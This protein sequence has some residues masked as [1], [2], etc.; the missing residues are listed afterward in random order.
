[1]KTHV[2]SKP[3]HTSTP[4]LQ[5]IKL[6]RLTER[7]RINHD[8]QRNDAR[9]SKEIKSKFSAML[10]AR[11]EEL[12]KGLLEKYGSTRTK[13]DIF[14]GLLK[15]KLSEKFRRMQ[16]K[17][18]QRALAVAS[19]MY[20]IISRKPNP[21]A[22]LHT[23]VKR[24]NVS[25]PRGSDPCRTIVECLFDYGS[26]PEERTDKRQY[27]CT[28]A[29]ALRYIIRKGI[30]PQKV[31]TP[32]QGESITNWAKREAQFCRQKTAS[33]TP[34]E[35]PKPKRSMKSESA[36]GELPVRRLSERRYRMLQK[37]AKT[38]VFLVDPEHNGRTLVVTV[39]KLASL[40]VDE[41]KRRP[42]KVRAEIQKTL[43]KAIQ[44]AAEK[45]PTMPL[46]P[47]PAINTRRSISFRTSPFNSIEA[48]WPSAPRG[49][50]CREGNR[51]SQ[52][53]II[54]KDL[55]REVE[56]WFGSLEPNLWCRPT[57]CWN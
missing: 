26:T 18:R 54:A 42:D 44:K 6:A 8:N 4:K 41:A 34:H 15:A 46:R 52:P 39:T 9:P 37:W 36:E 12:L 43:D 50:C 48:R 30:T 49:A 2:N 53:M 16:R 21:P 11:S 47:R 25:P 28:D 55:R 19:A 24:M 31:L 7:R 35:E 32:E 23:L 38:G 22:A 27:A 20:H 14:K 1:M 40:T 57:L 5:G 45:P 17:H 3:A 51:K 13:G 29:N 56:N 33:D 10:V